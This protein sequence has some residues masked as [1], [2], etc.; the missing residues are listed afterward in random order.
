MQDMTKSDFV[1]NT[2]SFILEFGWTV[3]ASAEAFATALKAIEGID[4][5]LWE[6]EEDDDG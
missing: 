6:K 4:E 5:D 2:L 1:S 3:E